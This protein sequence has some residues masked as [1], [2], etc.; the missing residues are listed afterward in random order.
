ML[1][2]NYEGM[3]ERVDTK[4]Y[5]TWDIYKEIKECMDLIQEATG[6][7]IHNQ[8]YEA[9][10]SNR[11]TKTLGNCHYDS[12]YFEPHYTITLS[13]KWLAT[14]E[15]QKIHDTIM[16]EVIHSM[17]GCMNHGP[18][19]KGYAAKICRRYPQ[20]TITRLSHD[21]NYSNYLKENNM[22]GCRYKLVCDTCGQSW[23]KRNK[24]RIFKLAALGRCACPYCKGSK[25]HIE[26]I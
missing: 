5:T 7:D 1:D 21:D 22:S 14:A 10:I 19:W 20:Y 11:F 16:H 2:M 6:V 25:F 24:T 4:N 18:K 17:P 13:A 26:N 9:R 15:P 12:D 3:V 23:E 8:R